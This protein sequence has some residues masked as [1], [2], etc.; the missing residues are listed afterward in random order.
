MVRARVQGVILSCTSESRRRGLPWVCFNHGLRPLPQVLQVAPIS[1]PP[2]G[3]ETARQKVK[4]DCLASLF[5]GWVLGPPGGPEIGAQIR[6]QR[7]AARLAV[8]A[9]ALRAGGGAQRAGC[10]WRD[11]PA[12]RSA[13]AALPDP[14]PRSRWR[15]LARPGSCGRTS[16]SRAAPPAAGPAGHGV[17]R[18]RMP[19]PT[20]YGRN[21]LR[22]A[23]S[24]SPGVRRRHVRPR[25]IVGKKICISFRKV[26]EL[27]MGR[28]RM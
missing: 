17:V 18:V 6:P 5:A 28:L 13:S 23:R 10:I 7:R 1:G 26:P 12:C 16:R 20:L 2:G 4:H 25:H 8:P 14:T 9:W 22:R 27:Q 19:F 15:A 21:P 11:V 3:P 24:L